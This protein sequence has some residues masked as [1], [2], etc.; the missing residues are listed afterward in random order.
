MKAFAAAVLMVWFSTGIQAQLPINHKFLVD[1]WVSCEN[2]DG[3]FAVTSKRCVLDSIVLFRQS[4]GLDCKHVKM[5]QGRYSLLDDG[6]LEIWWY[7][8]RDHS[9]NYNIKEVFISR[10]NPLK[11]WYWRFDETNGKLIIS[12]GNGLRTFQV[13]R[14]SHEQLV[15]RVLD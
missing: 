5:D 14:L 2:S 1:T 8:C 11:E 12:T 7:H 9:A 10:V 6:T 15:L 3:L 4:Y 13:S